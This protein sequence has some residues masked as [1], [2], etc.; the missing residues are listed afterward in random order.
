MSQY[1]IHIVDDEEDIRESLS[2]LLTSVGYSV[3]LHKDGFSLLNQCKPDDLATILLDVRMPELSGLNLQDRLI[4]ANHLQPLIFMS[5]HGDI[6][7]AVQAVQKGAMDFL[8]KPFR[9]IQLFDAVEKSF[10][11][12]SQEYALNKEKHAIANIVSTL[13]ERE[14]EVM[15]EVAIGL[16]N[17][18]IARKLDVS[19]RTIEI[20]R[21]RVFE[22]LAVDN[23]QQ[24][25]RK[26]ATG[27][28][29]D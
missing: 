4:E 20:H 27:G 23:A 25:I 7:M 16:S 5:G 3:T 9:D 8:E 28:L 1:P 14:N 2:L 15:R 24:L 6:S 21:S 29:L 13:T 26:L 17:K 12:L 11:R 18:L 22:K 19:P 10:L